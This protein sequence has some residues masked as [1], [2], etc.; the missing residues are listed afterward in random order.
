M[1]YGLLISAVHRLS[2][3]VKF[4]WKYMYVIIVILRVYRGEKLSELSNQIY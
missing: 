3:I 2:E 1:G 4:V